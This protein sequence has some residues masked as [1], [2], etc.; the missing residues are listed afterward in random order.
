[1][2]SHLLDEFDTA[3]RPIAVVFD[4]IRRVDP[5]SLPLLVEFVAQPDDKRPKQ[6]IPLLYNA[7]F[8]LPAGRYAVELVSKANTP[9]HELKGTLSL[10]LGRI[11]APAREW[12]VDIAMPG[13]WGRAFDLP[14]DVNLVGFHGSPE[15]EQARPSLRIRPISVVDAHA[16]V[17]VDE[18]LSARISTHATVFFHDEKAMPDGTGFWTPGRSSLTVT[19]AAQH[20]KPPRIS[21]RAGPVPTSVK[22]ITEN[23]RQDI[24]LEP[25]AQR[26]L[27]LP[28]PASDLTRLTIET[29]T[30]FVPARV[31]SASHDERLLGC[32][33]E[34]D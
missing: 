33:V 22:L 17:P 28:I 8:A 31:D 23:W 34:V 29:R 15:V 26:V 12:D 4:P 18:V 3:R 25:G 20:E 21:V 6:P 30:G 2:R 24:D 10:Q 32:W 5:Q 16:R 13:M 11:G 27:D 9:V 14:I 19:V 7:R 1:M